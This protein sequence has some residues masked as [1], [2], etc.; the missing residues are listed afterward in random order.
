MSA[1]EGAVKP[2]RSTIPA[3]LDRLSWSPFH[4]RM[5]AGLGAAWIL[6]GLQ[7]TIASSVTGVLIKPD[8]LDMTSSQVGL[9]ATVYLVGQVVGALV[10][11]RLSDQLGRKRLL[12]V[13]LLLYL[14]GTGLA[15]FTFNDGGHFWLFNFYATRFIAGM[16][17]GGQYAA[18]N[19]AIDE[20]MP[21][22]YR[23]RVDIWIN[24]SYWAGAIIGSFASLV[25]LNAFAPN[26]GWRLA[27]LMGPVL[28]LVVPV[29]A[30]ALPESPRWLMT[31]GR[32]EEAEAELAKIEEAVRRSGQELAPVD[33][34][35]ALELVPE[36]RYGYV[37]FLG[38]V[39]AGIR[40]A[41]SSAPRS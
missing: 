31:H 29:V 14:F 19:S 13:T 30:R 21:S 18:I 15:A 39:S 12:V 28:A 38:L 37:T 25:F 24:G 4:T 27:F 32:M 16:G 22:K 1:A 23:G 6:D 10:F 2:I 41:R 34:S 3:R 11:G 17:I 40:S 26:V 35:Q 8:T 20:M 36:K 33:D 7:I 5:V 9:I